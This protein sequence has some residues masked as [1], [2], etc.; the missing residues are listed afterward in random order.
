MD[1]QQ[2]KLNLGIDIDGVI[3]DSVNTFLNYLNKMFNKNFKYEDIKEYRFEN[4][5]KVSEK[6]MEYF[7]KKFTEE[8]G[9]LKL[10]PFP[11]AKKFL[12][13]IKEYFNIYIITS[14]PK[15]LTEEMT[16]KWLEKNKIYYDKIFFMENDC[17]YLTAKKYN[18]NL[19]YFIE[20]CLEIALNISQYIPVFV[21]KTP[22]NFQEKLINENIIYV[23]KHAEIYKYFIEK[24]IIKK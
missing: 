20:D 8:K 5:Y 9:W 21:L 10:E 4:I 11:D 22:Y 17:K 23:N 1:Y 15:E 2:K 6:E 3:A 24:Q 19:N 13:E 14:R 7:T 12:D 18:I 16:Y